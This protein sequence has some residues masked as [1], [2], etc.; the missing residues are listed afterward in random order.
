MGAT[1][2]VAGV[3]AVPLESEAPGIFLC[4]NDWSEVQWFAEM[5]IGAGH[6]KL[7]VWEVSLPDNAAFVE[8]DGA[9]GYEYHPEPIPPP[10]IRLIRTDW[11]PSSRFAE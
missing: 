9:P 7:D 1:H 8:Y 5:A 4:R 3:M 6:L 11:S 10:A 2:G